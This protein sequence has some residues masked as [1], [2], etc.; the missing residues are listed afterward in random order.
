MEAILEKTISMILDNI[1]ENIQ[2]A[3]CWSRFLGELYNYEVINRKR[4]IEILNE[5]LEKACL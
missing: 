5:F 1:E 3:V 2:T 4:M